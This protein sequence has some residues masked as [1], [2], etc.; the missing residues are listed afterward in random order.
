MYFSLSAGVHFRRSST[1][2]P[3]HPSI[4]VAIAFRACA[5]HTRP[6]ARLGVELPSD[7]DHE[8][9]PQP[10]D[11]HH[12]RDGSLG[13]SSGDIWT[14]H[15]AGVESADHPGR[16]RR[17]RHAGQR[18]RRQDLRRGLATDPGV[19]G[20]G[21]AFAFQLD[22]GL[23]VG[24]S[25]GGL[26]GGPSQSS[27]L[28][29]MS[30]GRAVGMDDPEGVHKRSLNGTSKGIPP[31]VGALAVQASPRDD[32]DL[33]RRV[34]CDE[35]PGMMQQQPAQV[36]CLIVFFCQSLAIHVRVSSAYTPLSMLRRD[37]LDSLRPVDRFTPD[38]APS[39]ANASYAYTRRMPT[40][41]PLFAIVPDLASSYCYA[42]PAPSRCA[43]PTSLRAS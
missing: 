33:F 38:R 43:R 7:Q 23:P 14:H 24:V 29:W 12:T 34:A 18:G 37:V 25:S 35:P 30:G 40:R 4:G 41:T 20:D 36:M 19:G 1:Y 8:I 10:D 13:G 16:A 9:D 5:T 2:L 15:V 6:I 28:D 11:V 26:L 32:G 27:P 3:T 22:D 21:G 39:L 42:F 31:T 17:G